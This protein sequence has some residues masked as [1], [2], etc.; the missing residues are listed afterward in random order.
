[1]GRVA[2]LPGKR[3]RSR[4]V[5]PGPGPRPGS[6]GGRGCGCPSAP[7]MSMFPSRQAHPVLGTC[8]PWHWKD[9]IQVLASSSNQTCY[10]PARRA[11]RPRRRTTT[12]NRPVTNTAPSSCLS[13]RLPIQVQPNP[14]QL[15][16]TGSTGSGKARRCT[17]G[18]LESQLVRVG[19]A[20]VS[21]IFFLLT[22]LACSSTLTFAIRHVRREIGALATQYCLR[23]PAE[24]VIGF[25]NTRS[26]L[27]LRSLLKTSTLVA[28]LSRPP[29]VD[30]SSTSHP[31]AVVLRPTL[32]E[33]PFDP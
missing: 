9:P 26:D 31:R 21:S 17:A 30:P 18:S 3:R 22:P 13:P 4:P 8:L 7:S 33:Q 15:D 24:A 14:A 12:P 29:L 23:L 32:T 10:L 27:V 1:M 11:T 28:Q 19:L 2:K 20:L 25:L 5:I 16:P 6:D